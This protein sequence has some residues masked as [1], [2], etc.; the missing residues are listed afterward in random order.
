[1][2]ITVA[3]IITAAYGVITEGPTVWQSV[4]WTSPAHHAT[5]IAGAYARADEIEQALAGEIKGVS[6][7]LRCRDFREELTELL[8][9]QRAGDTS[10][11]TSERIAT[12]RRLMEQKYEC[13]RFDE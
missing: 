10:V 7:Y 12:L 1:M 4:G 13:D 11:E 6:D 3:G 2:L 9:Q 8:K 5:D